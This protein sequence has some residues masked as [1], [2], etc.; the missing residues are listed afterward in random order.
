[1]FNNLRQFRG[2]AAAIAAERRK[3][4][5][6]NAAKRPLSDSATRRFLPRVAAR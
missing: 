5:R 1:M 2:E 4:F 3:A 6:Q